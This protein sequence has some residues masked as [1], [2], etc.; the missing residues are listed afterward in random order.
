[1]ATQRRNV[2]FT[3]HVQGV[4]FRYTAKQ[5]AAA[6]DVTGYIR[7]RPDGAVEMVL[8]GEADEIDAVLADLGSRMEG[9]IREVSQDTA[10]VTGEF[11]D[12]G[13]RF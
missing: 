13:V 2:L 4:G 5:A 9:Y 6:R 10:E 3:G 1:M 12:F 7:N 8:E 11:A